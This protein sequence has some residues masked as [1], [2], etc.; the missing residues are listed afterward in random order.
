MNA[1]VKINRN[2]FIFNG[3]ETVNVMEDKMDKMKQMGV[4]SD[5]CNCSVYSMATV[6]TGV[7]LAIGTIIYSI[8][9]M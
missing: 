4:V 9:T 3:E 1:E 7:L 5:K 2:E 6:G 8:I